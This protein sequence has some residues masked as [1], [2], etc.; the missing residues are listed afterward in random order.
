[1]LV[2]GGSGFLGAWCIV[3]LLQAGYRVRTT[4]RSLK[5][6]ADVRAMVK[7]GGAE[8]GQDLEVV[9]ADL[10]SDAGW[11]EAVAGCKFVL[12]VASPFPVNAPKHEDDLVS[13]PSHTMADTQSVE[14]HRLCNATSRAR[15]KPP[16]IEVPE[17]ASANS[18]LGC[19][20]CSSSC[21]VYVPPHVWHTTFDHRMSQKWSWLLLLNQPCQA[22]HAIQR[23]STSD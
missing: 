17:A 19:D 14:C 18:K 1:M 10:L 8:P 13:S 7:Q 23:L 16:Q 12:H 3:K 2:T 6:E 21:S 20:A 9:A 4:V 15:V 11:P 5:R 22:D